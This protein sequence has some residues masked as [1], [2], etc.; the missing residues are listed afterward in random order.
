MCFISILKLIRCRCS[1]KLIYTVGYNTVYN[2]IVVNS[3]FAT[4]SHNPD[5]ILG[6]D[7]GITK[8]SIPNP[9]VE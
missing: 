1:R 8:A 6:W 7:A 9:G 2:I 5:R 3:R 4:R